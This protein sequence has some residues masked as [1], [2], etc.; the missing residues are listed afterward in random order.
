MGMPNA[1]AMRRRELIEGSLAP[2]SIWLS[3]LTVR[4]TWLASWASVR[5]RRRRSRRIPSPIVGA[6]ASIASN[7][8]PPAAPCRVRWPLSRGS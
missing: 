8:P 5:P 6:S 1:C 4:L 2:R 7:G 3:A